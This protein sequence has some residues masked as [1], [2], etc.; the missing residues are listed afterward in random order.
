MDQLQ[1]GAALEALAAGYDMGPTAMHVARA[2]RAGE[3]PELED[4]EAAAI[5]VP[6]VIDLI[7]DEDA[8]DQAL[9][10]ASFLGTALQVE[11]E[12]Y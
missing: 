10:L 2:L 9:A 3:W 11:Y 12:V 5:E 1:A 7:E 8:K 4:V 6:G